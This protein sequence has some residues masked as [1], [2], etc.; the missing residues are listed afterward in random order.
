MSDRDIFCDTCG[1]FVGTIRDAKLRKGLKFI[2]PDC[3]CQ[4]KTIDDFNSMGAF[5]DIFGN[6]ISGKKK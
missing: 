5:G 4:D 3:D 1:N 6:I 2:C